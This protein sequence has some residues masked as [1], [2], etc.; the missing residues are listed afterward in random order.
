M[1]FDAVIIKFVS[2]SEER[3]LNKKLLPVPSFYK[4]EHAEKVFRVP[5]E[6]RASQAKSWQKEHHINPASEDQ[7]KTCLILIDM[8]NTF[9]LPE[10]EL[11]VGG[12]SGRGA[13]EDS[14]RLS[15]F[16]YKNLAKITQITATM[17]SHF[18]IQ[19]FHSPYLINQAGENPPANTFVSVEDVENGVWQFNHYAAPTLGVTPEQGQE[20]LLHYVKAL[21]TQGKY[22]LYIWPFHAMLGGIGHALVSILEEA[23]FFHSSCRFSQPEY[24]FKGQNPATEH[25]S[26]ISPEVSEDAQGNLLVERD[27]TLLEKVINYDRVL[28]AGQAKSH[29][30]A[31]TLDDLWK[32]IQA[33]NP[34]LVEK[35]FLLDDCASAVVIPGVVD[36]TDEAEKAFMRFEKAGM[37]RITSDYVL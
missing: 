12:R 24:I 2:K 26:A 14:K 11:F 6:E 23:I 30:V 17:D 3:I 16:I 29:C 25:Y 21:A 13:I 19:I 33:V 8:Q 32:E 22:Q 4:E 7:I 28:I 34:K 1:C 10:F 5:Y 20:N 15:K 9:C 18:S 37:Q 27:K 35:V 36:Y 31:A